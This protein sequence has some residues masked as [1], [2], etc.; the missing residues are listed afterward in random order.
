MNSPVGSLSFG[1]AWPGAL[2]GLDEIYVGGGVTLSPLKR[3]VARLL[4]QVDRCATVA[5]EERRRPC[6][7][8]WQPKPAGLLRTLPVGLEARRAGVSETGLCPEP[9]SREECPGEVCPTCIRAL[10]APGIETDHPNQ[11]ERAG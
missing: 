5:A 1:Q 3:G 8:A 6:H 10:Q 2:A 9:D 11:V 4:D 7:L